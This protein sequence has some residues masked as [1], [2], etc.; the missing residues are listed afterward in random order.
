MLSR[1]AFKKILCGID[2]NVNDALS[3]QTKS[4]IL[5]TDNLTNLNY[6]ELLNLKL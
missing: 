4:E 3:F 2:I 1:Y 5:F 6:A